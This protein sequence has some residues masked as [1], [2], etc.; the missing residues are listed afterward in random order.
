VKYTLCAILIAL[1]VL[2]GPVETS[3]DALRH[4]PKH[5]IYTV[6]SRNGACFTGAFLSADDKEVVLALPQQ[7]EHSV[8][9]P[10]ILRI[11]V[12]E[13]A[14]LHSAVYSARSSWADLLALATPPYYSDL[15]VITSDNRQ[16]KGPLLGVSP[17]QL[18]LFVDSKEMRFTKEYVDRVFLTST[19]PTVKRPGAHR[20]LIKLSKKGNSQTQLV[21]LY[22]VTERQDDSPVNCSLSDRRQSPL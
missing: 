11:S 12:G 10:D 4:L 13:T 15:L 16:F 20:G 7:G 22:E 6:L 5:H 9:R 8:A 19:E 17:D 1:P 14:D 21:P 2:S 18:S 3:W